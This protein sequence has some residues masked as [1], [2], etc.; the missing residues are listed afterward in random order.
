MHQNSVSPTAQF[1]HVPTWQGKSL[2]PSTWTS[3]WAS[4]FTELTTW[5]FDED[6]RVNGP[7]SEYEAAFEMLT[8]HPCIVH[9]GHWDENTGVDAETGEPVV[10]DA[11]VFYA[12]DECELG[13]WR[14]E[15]IRFNQPY[16]RQYLLGLP[17]SEPAS[18]WEDPQQTLFYHVQPR[19]LHKLF[20]SL[21]N[22]GNRF[23]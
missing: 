4:C 12:Y 19:S 10:F 13:M 21:M 3:S 18:Q 15:V 14:C 8:D 17:P 1:D 2:Q 5:F 16:I 22:S 6:V 20:R 9:G 7:W 23:P 11:S